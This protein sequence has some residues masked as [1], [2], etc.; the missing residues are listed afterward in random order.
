MDL[1]CFWVNLRIIIPSISGSIKW[2][3][4]RPSYFFGTNC[5]NYTE[6]RKRA[7]NAYFSTTRR[8]K[9]SDL[10]GVIHISTSLNFTVS[11]L[12]PRSSPLSDLIQN[13]D[14][15]HSMWRWNLI[16]F[17]FMMR[18]STYFSPMR[19]II[20]P[21]HRPTILIHVLSVPYPMPPAPS[22]KPTAPW[23][24]TPVPITIRVWQ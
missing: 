5:T 15:C 17:M 13:I 10:G 6:K 24:Q 9:R 8:R 1:C 21:G 12:L 7:N 11:P 3:A 19:L 20:P 22:P 16:I 18:I 4:W 14:N 2:M 23:T